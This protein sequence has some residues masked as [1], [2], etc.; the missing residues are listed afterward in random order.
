QGRVAVRQHAREAH[1]EGRL[2][3]GAQHRQQGRRRAPEG[4]PEVQA[5]SALSARRN[6]FLLASCQA[7]L[8][9]NAVTLVAV[10]ALAGYAL[11][12]DKTLSTLPA[13]TYVLGGP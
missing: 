13:T 11:A 4:D 10:G 9:T 8:L 3:D 7:L 12:P 6:V 5:A 1:R 2:H